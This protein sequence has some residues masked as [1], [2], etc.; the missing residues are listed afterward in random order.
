MP[1]SLLLLPLLAVFYLP[2][3]LPFLLSF[4]IKAHEWRGLKWSL[5]IASIAAFSFRALA[6]LTRPDFGNDMAGS[7]AGAG[8]NLTW[9]WVSGG[10]CAFVAVV[11][12]LLLRGL[13]PRRIS[14]IPER[15]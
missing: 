15:E 4:T 12:G 10:A 1:A 3:Y 2:I 6:M 13:H 5:R 7:F 14:G 9:T 11:I 8:Y